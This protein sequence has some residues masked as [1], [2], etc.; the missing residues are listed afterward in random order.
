[1]ATQPIPSGRPVA[2]PIDQPK[3]EKFLERM[4]NDIGTAVRGGLCYI[5]DRLGLFKALAEAGPVTVEQLAGKTGLNERYLREWLGAMVTAEY[6]E[7]DVWTKQYRLPP[8]HALPLAN[9]D[10][11]YFAGGAL[12][13]IQPLVSVAPK[14]AEAF[15]TGKGVP[16]SEYSPEMFE[17]IERFTAPWYKNQL[18]QN[19]IPAMPQ[20][21]AA[22]KAGGSALDVG[23][24][25]GRAAIAIAR[26]FPNARVYGY[27]N[28][29]LS[30]ERA[31]HNAH[32]ADVGDR[33]TFDVVDCTKLPK[34]NFDFIT[35]FDV[36]HDAVNP[37]GLMASIHGA[38][39]PDGTYLLLEMNC[40]P[41]LQD[42]VNP[43]G[44]LLY[45]VSTLY[46]MT[47]SLAHG[48]EGIG[49]VMGEPRARDMAQH[50]GFRSFRRLPIEDP[51]SLLYELRP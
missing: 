5:G 22:L 21:E 15:R 11:P 16:Q 9:E 14:V 36:V 2:Q 43:L 34:N 38:L 33:V 19:W 51:F 48:G 32:E 50:A 35:T 49:A 26:A 24:G 7:Y 28:H 41:D 4:L 23:C 10:F 8:E 31:R 45:S 12:Q 25:S 39:T 42:N 44:R 47:T 20:V 46:C 17:S 37:S 6:V 18:V 29:P 13:M 30:I 3:L 27:D 40:H 1:M